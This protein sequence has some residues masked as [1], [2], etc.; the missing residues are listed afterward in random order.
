[1]I[2][3]ALVVACAAE[4]TTT[5]QPARSTATPTA[6]P[7]R[8][9]TPTPTRAFTVPDCAETDCDCPD[10]DSPAHAQW[11]HDNHDPEDVHRLDR[12]EDGDAC[13]LEE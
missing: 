7:T 5:V 9:A 12:D 8:S 10:F 2:L 4:K 1:V 6:A 13:E 3:A 11:F